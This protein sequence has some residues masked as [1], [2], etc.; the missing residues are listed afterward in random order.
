MHIINNFISK[1]KLIMHEKLLLYKITIV[2]FLT[3]ILVEFI[4]L[5][6]IYQYIY[7]T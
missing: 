2:I 1:M 4:S 7:N 6:A 3:S 5:F